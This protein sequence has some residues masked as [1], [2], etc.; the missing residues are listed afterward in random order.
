M[1]RKTAIQNTK[2]RM[3]TWRE[4]DKWDKEQR[5]NEIQSYR[6]D[7]PLIDEG[8]QKLVSG[9]VSR[10]VQAIWLHSDLRASLHIKIAVGRFAR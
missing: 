4:A 1:S 5:T 2:S 8:W 10:D 3:D 9:D 6:F 7:R